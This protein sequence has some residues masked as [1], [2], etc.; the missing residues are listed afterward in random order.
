MKI[1]ALKKALT[2]VLAGLVLLSGIPFQGIWGGL[3]KAQAMEAA[4]QVEFFMVDTHRIWPNLPG[5]CDKAPSNQ[6]WGWAHQVRDTVDEDDADC[7]KVRIANPSSE[8]SQDFRICFSLGSGP[9]EWTRCTPWASE[10]GGPTGMLS[11]EYDAAIG[12]MQ[13]W[14]EVRDL[15]VGGTIKNVRIGLQWYELDKGKPCGASG[16]IAWADEN[17]PQ[18]WWTWGGHDDNNP[19]CAQMYMNASYEAPYRADNAGNNLDGAVLEPGKTYGADNNFRITMRNMG[20]TWDSSTVVRQTGNCDGYVPGPDAGPCSDTKT[21]TS[22]NVRL[23]RIDNEP[24]TFTPSPLAYEQDVTATHTSYEG[25]VCTSFSNTP[26]SGGGIETPLLNAVLGIHTAHALVEAPQLDLPVSDDLSGG[27]I[28]TDTATEWYD[29]MTQGPDGA[30]TAPGTATFPVTFT[31]PTT[32]GEYTLRFQMQKTDGSASGT[33]SEGRFGQ[34]T[35][36]KVTVAEVPVEPPFPPVFDPTL[37]M[38]PDTA[39]VQMG[40]QA[41]FRVF[42]DADGK[43]TDAAEQ[44]VT[45]DAV[46]TID[47][48]VARNDGNGRFTGTGGGQGVVT[49]TY[50]GLMQSGAITV[51]ETPVEPPV[52]ATPSFVVRP[53]SALVEV[54]QT[55]TLEAFYD[56]DSDGPQG[57]QNVTTQASWVSDGPEV[58]SKGDGV[59]AGVSVGTSLVHA[60][61]Q[62]K[63]ASASLTTY[64]V[65]VEPPVAPTP[66]LSMTP[67][68]ATVLVGDDARFRVRY[69]ADGDGP[70]EAQDV[71]ALATWTINNDVAVNGGTGV[72]TGSHAG[73]ATITATYLGKTDT[74][75]L[76]V[77]P[78]IVV[79]PPVAPTPTLAMLPDT[80]QVAVGQQVNFVTMY[81]PDGDGP[82][83]AQ[84]VTANTAWN[85][86]GTVARNDGQ[87]AFT[88]TNTG[89]AVVTGDYQGLRAQAALSVYTVVVE[90]PVVPSLTVSPSAVSASVGDQV[91]FK[92]FYDPDSDG[93][94]AEKEVTTQASWSIDSNIARNDGAGVFTGTNAGSGSVHAIYLGLAAAGDLVM[95]AV[96]EPPVPATPTFNIT[97]DSAVIVVG[98]V[99]RFEAAYDPD[100]SGPQAAQNVSGIASWSIDSNVARNDGAGVF[101]GTNA[102]NGVVTVSYQGMSARADVGVQQAPQPPVV[103]VPT[104]TVSP[105]AATLTVGDQALFQVFYDPDGTGPE[106]PRD[107]SDTASWSVTSGIARNDGAGFF[108][109]TNAGSGTVSVNYLGLTD[110]ADL[111]I[112]AAP[113][114]PPNPPGPPPQQTPY[115]TLACPV[116]EITVQAG[117]MGSFPVQVTSGNGFI[118]NVTV[119]PGQLPQGV[120]GVGT[121]M[122]VGAGET[123]QGIVSV[124]VATDAPS[125]SSFITF[126]ASA[127]NATDVR[128]SAK[129]NVVASNVIPTLTTTPSTATVTVGNSATFQVFYDPDGAGPQPAQDVSNVATWTIDGDVASNDGGGI[130]TGT[131][132]GTGTIHVTYLGLATTAGLTVDPAP[133][134]E[135]PTVVTTTTTT[136]P[137]EPPGPGD[138]PTPNG[139]TSTTPTNGG[140][141]TTTTTT[142]TTPVA[143]SC[144]FKSNLATV[145]VPP[146]KAVML[147]WSCDNVVQAC[148][149]TNTSNGATLITGGA[150]GSTTATPSQT[151]TY[152]LS[153]D[154]FHQDMTVRVFD[155]STRVEIL[156]K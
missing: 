94:L 58:K 144:V 55:T 60:T 3:Q 33:D 52:P 123:T 1:R 42:Y 46:W 74:G 10:G 115:I 6:Q 151:T 113:V 35:E 121:S 49:A 106:A 87:G 23:A 83:A 48:G 78:G 40:E 153:C 84:N 14:T 99:V 71:S 9:G 63:N 28:C 117:D 73:I 18:S 140:G 100:G 56:P 53:S 116:S 118:G 96:V 17:T 41:A 142:T 110:S 109:G 51:Y 54:G 64:E 141:A 146:A 36:I 24:F 69:D 32:P 88:G 103:V 156:P 145:F 19:G 89:N 128:C 77:E 8:Y 13:N 130:F 39:S 120:A 68:S 136:V 38:R 126:T 129:L 30:I 27:S 81:D 25:Q 72:F 97:P 108:T 95:N 150:S 29:F 154:G 70:Q 5:E 82:Q 4:P 105:K 131:N 90:P 26:S 44:D 149:V 127:S 86:S 34:V 132:A 16:G 91:S 148:R 133:P 101:T 21:V 57:E 45:S 80:A 92:V 47:N 85:I 20:R 65:P 37:T 7:A 22:P 147:S 67:G 114:V 2:G 98:D 134:V 139:S 124:D 125:S 31:A 66:T 79:E 43:G 93:P 75:S 59:F 107:V 62:D 50:K 61:Y 15:P 138:P 135:P 143:A 111:T 112:Q 152:R 119:T 104:L 137:V 122:S 12:Y 76:T 155:V 11:S 102:G